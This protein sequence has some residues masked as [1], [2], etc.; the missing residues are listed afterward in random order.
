[1]NIKEYS[2]FISEQIKID[3]ETE[4]ISTR[5]SFLK[6][7]TDILMN[8]EEFDNFE[9]L[10][11]ESIGK[12]RRKIQIDGY[13]YDELDQVLSLFIVPSLTNFSGETLISTEA[14][15]YFSRATSFIEDA[16]LMLQN[17]EESSPG[18]GLAYDINH[19]YKIVEKYRVY[20]LTDMVMSKLIKMLEHG[21]INDKV[22]EYHIW[23]IE[24][25]F[26][27]AESGSVKEDVAIDLK[28]YVS[29]GIP[30]L[31]ASE[32]DDYKAYLCNIPGTLLAKLYN[33]FGGR[34]LE[35]NVRSFF[36]N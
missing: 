35:G 23:D 11:F 12:N 16:E 31:M 22:V 9:Y 32:T 34:L 6:N 10:P 20:L 2:E 28:D 33:E 25:I 24:R 14:E 8:S 30:C 26:N 5:E 1:M 7:Y 3:V 27:I 4:K 17:A 29:N 21:T 19:K 13:S 15:K 36:A 18:Y